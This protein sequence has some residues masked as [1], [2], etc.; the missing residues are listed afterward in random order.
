MM[1]QWTRCAS[2]IQ[3]LPPVRRLTWL[4]SLLS[5]P[6]SSCANTSYRAEHTRTKR[7]AR[8]APDIRVAG[9]LRIGRWLDQADLT[10]RRLA[11]E[12][13]QD[14]VVV[15]RAQATRSG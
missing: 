13:L 9:H 10:R 1:A 3:A 15:T 11:P 6:Q 5:L 4:R 8:S 7:P 12:A 2:V 14:S